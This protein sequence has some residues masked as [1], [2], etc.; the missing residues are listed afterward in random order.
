MKERER[1]S[2]VCV[3]MHTLLCMCLIV[4]CNYSWYIVLCVCV[5]VCVGVPSSVC[6]CV[7]VCVCA[8]CNVIVPVS[9]RHQE[10]SCDGITSLAFVSN[11]LV[12]LCGIYVASVCVSVATGCLLCSSVY[13]WFC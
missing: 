6:V 13:V 4:V 10:V 1:K 11:E 9:T 5:C 2:G 8:H 12:R 7:C 3:Y